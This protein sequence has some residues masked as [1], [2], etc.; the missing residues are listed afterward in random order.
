MTPAARE[1]RSAWDG[2]AYTTVPVVLWGRSLVLRASA[3][4]EHAAWER[5]LAAWAALDAETRGAP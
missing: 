5:L 4:A 2:W 3:V 1:L